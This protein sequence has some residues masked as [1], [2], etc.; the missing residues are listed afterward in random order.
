MSS[1]LLPRPSGR[2]LLPIA[3]VAVL[4]LSACGGNASGDATNAGAPATTTERGGSGNDRTGPGNGP[5]D[6]AD[7]QA[8]LKKQ[9]VELPERPAGQNGE[10]P[11][12]A[13]EGGTPEGGAPEG[14]APPE[15][16]LPGGGG[17]PPQGR[18]GDGRRGG[19]FADLSD[20]DREK[21]QQA[22]EKCGGGP[23]GPG[24]AG[25]RGGPAG[26]ARGRRPD[27]NDADYQASIKAYAACV[28]K[29]GYDLPDPDFSGKGPIFDPKEVDQQD[30][31]FKKA[32]KACQSTLRRQ[33]VGR[34][35]RATTTSTT[36]TSTST[37]N[38]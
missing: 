7:L 36:P 30:A 2:A 20:E 3:A 12:G 14:G 34:T 25:R 35:G 24:G 11:E 37:P 32:S 5:Q 19:P 17:A 13:P 28:R 31:T 10:R 18:D 33:G 8:C 38:S 22:M 6:M 16:G 29:N 26:Q 9:G 1:M 23:G 27:V 21:L 4:A 15:G